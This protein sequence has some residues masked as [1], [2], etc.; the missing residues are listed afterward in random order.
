MLGHP[1]LL[2]SR[3]ECDALL[4][5]PGADQIGEADPRA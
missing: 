5:H 1:D 3:L 2:P 4:T